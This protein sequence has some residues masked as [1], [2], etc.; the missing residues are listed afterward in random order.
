MGLN[1]CSNNEDA[2]KYWLALSIGEH[3]SN[4]R[5]RI[6]SRLEI[7]IN[8]EDAVSLQYQL[9]DL[10]VVIEYGLQAYIEQVKNVI[11]DTN[12]DSLA[13]KLDKLLLGPD[14]DLYDY[15]QDLSTDDIIRKVET[16]DVNANVSFI[17]E[18]R[19][20]QLSKRLYLILQQVIDLNEDRVKLGNLNSF[21][22]LSVYSLSFI[23]QAISQLPNSTKLLTLV[24][25]KIN[26]VGNLL[27]PE[28][29]N[30]NIDTIYPIFKK[31][32]ISHINLLNNDLENDSSNLLVCKLRE[33]GNNLM[34]NLA[35]AQAIQIYTQAFDLSSIKAISQMPQIL[36][37]RAIAYIGLNCFPEAILDLNQ[38]VNCD[39]QFTPAWTQLG[40]CQLYMGHSLTALKSYLLALKTSVGEV[41]HKKMSRAEHEEYKKLKIKT[42]LPQ[43][44]QRLCL[45]IALTERRAYQQ[46]EPEQEIRHVISEVRR[47]L[48]YLRAEA[49]TEDERQYFT[50]LP[51]LR[52]PS[53][54]SRSERANRLRPNI[55]TQDVS[56]NM[57]ASNGMESV[58]IT[59]SPFERR[60]ND[61]ARETT[62]NTN[63]TPAVNPATGLDRGTNTIR[64][65]MNEFGDMLEDRTRSNLTTQT[66]TSDANASTNT[67]DAVNSENSGNS[68]SDPENSSTLNGSGSSSQ[69]ETSATQNPLA[70]HENML[71]EVLR[72][73]LPG[74]TNVISHFA[75]SNGN[76][77]VIVNGQ[78]IGL[79]RVANTNDNTTTTNRDN[80]SQTDNSNSAPTTTDTTR[81]DEDE[82]MPEPE[83]LD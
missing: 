80:A 39:W 31:I 1:D 47:I 20:K 55:L 22:T 3:L 17:S 40:Y 81:V 4:V 66:Q 58:T 68:N 19:E 75:T 78:E 30:A 65:F 23:S 15:S 51:Q 71:S 56:Q 7:M 53:L 26:K 77:R 43:F 27:N 37:N 52:E 67:V 69:R 10:D 25:E 41:G 13:Y 76:S 18:S 44:V 48:A 59:A 54:I 73:V 24:T 28:A 21:D 32:L 5:S 70:R 45:A 38:A 12:Y 46:N 36:T 61:T 6:Q 34:S 50:Y 33:Q 64:E 8:K 82:E 49:Q 74:I 60:V 72:G 2:F 62:S 42:V 35:F 63:N 16:A 9:T 57:L 79:N 14:I 83:D 29:L 11:G